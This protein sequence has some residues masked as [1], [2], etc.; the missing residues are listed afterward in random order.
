MCLGFC[1]HVISEVIKLSEHLRYGSIVFLGADIDVPVVSPAET[2][3]GQV[4]IYAGLRLFQSRTGQ[5][6][7]KIIDCFRS[8][9]RNY[10]KILGDVGD[11]PVG[12][13]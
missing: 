5:R 7:R 4:L 13:F 2:S 11:K 3:L 10:L 6:P 12:L 9:P 1:V 8:N